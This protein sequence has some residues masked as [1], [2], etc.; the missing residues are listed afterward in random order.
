MSEGV[1]KLTVNRELH[2]WCAAF[3]ELEEAIT[4]VH[5]MIELAALAQTQSK[6]RELAVFALFET[7][8]LAQV[9]VDQYRALHAKLAGA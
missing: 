1:I 4:D 3:M 9:L 8:K 2:P 5:R 7:R 6:D